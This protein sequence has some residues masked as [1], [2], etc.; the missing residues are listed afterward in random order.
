MTARKGALS[1]N[2]YKCRRA[3]AAPGDAGSPLPITLSAYDVTSTNCGCSSWSR[4]VGS[5]IVEMTCGIDARPSS[6]K[7]HAIAIAACPV[8]L[9]VRHCSMNSCPSW[10]VNSMSCKPH[11]CELRRRR[12][13]PAWCAQRHQ[14]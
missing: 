11:L 3:P 7:S 13:P 14:R 10:T 12:Q 5:T 6:M 2:M 1:D 9:P 8:R 4:C